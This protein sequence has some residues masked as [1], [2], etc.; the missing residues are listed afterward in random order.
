LIN[1]DV[2]DSVHASVH[3]SSDICDEAAHSF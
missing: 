1:Q 3:S 2:T